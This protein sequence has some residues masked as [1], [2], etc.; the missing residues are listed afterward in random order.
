MIREL[1][2]D[3]RDYHIRDLFSNENKQKKNFFRYIN[4]YI[5]N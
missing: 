2:T 1:M 5:G 4:F 3:E